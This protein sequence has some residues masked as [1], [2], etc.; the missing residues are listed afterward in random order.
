M[1]KS[2]ELVTIEQSNVLQVF[3]TEKGLD[4]LL[5]KVQEEINSF[6]PDVT[7]K[8]GR[9]A[10]ASIAY[11]VSQTKSYLDNTGKKLVDDLKKQPKAVDAERKRM[12]ELLDKWRDEVRKPLT[13]LEDSEKE[14]IGK[15]TS[16]TE[17]EGLN[18]EFV[19]RKLEEAKSIDIDFAV[20]KP[21]EL[22]KK[23]QDTI[24][25]LQSEFE[26]LKDSEAKQA[27]IERLQKEAAEREQKEREEIIAREAAEKAR[28]EAEQKAKMEAE[29]AERERLRAIQEKE[30]AERDR[31]E[32]E[33]RAE[34]MR[35]EA[36]ERAEREKQE[37]IERERREAEHRENMRI[38]AEQRAKAEAEE[39]E[40]KRL[41]N[42]EH[43]RA[44]NNEIL[45]A[46]VNGEIP[47]DIAKEVIKLAAQG[48]A[49]RMIINY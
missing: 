32:S 9:D 40:R 49:G 28:I 34:R 14:V 5:S 17:I 8:K 48:L 47:E 13:D 6:V 35:I 30:Q 38:Q 37:A 12:R 3:T 11:K 29:K 16:L 22:E 18:S 43:K 31:I 1:S 26:S 15:F 39:A 42:V 23:K 10:I 27:E 20:I 44:V 41:A 7:T 46:L 24:E 33:Q 21:K 45:A 19:S 25:F 2:N 36:Q 4:P